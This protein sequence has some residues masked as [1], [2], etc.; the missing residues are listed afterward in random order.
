MKGTVHEADC[1]RKRRYMTGTG[2][3][4]GTVQEEDGT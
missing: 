1:T 2:Y 3:I 4:K